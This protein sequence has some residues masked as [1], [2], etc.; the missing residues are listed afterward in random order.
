MSGRFDAGSALRVS[1]QWYCLTIGLF[2][3]IT[4][5]V[6][7]KLIQAL[8]EAKLMSILAGSGLIAFLCSS[9]LLSEYLGELAIPIGITISAAFVTTAMAVIWI[10]KCMK[11]AI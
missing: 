1:Q 5:V 6:F 4:G 3:A 7:A 11:K 8:G 2:P 9:Y 10:N